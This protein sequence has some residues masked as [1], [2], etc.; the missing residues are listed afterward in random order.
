M[1]R[2]L[3]I[4]LVLFLIPA[5]LNAQN[6]FIK[7]FPNTCDCGIGIVKILPFN[8][9]YLALHYKWAIDKS[10]NAENGFL[11]FNN[12]NDEYKNFVIK[13]SSDY[14]E[15][16]KDFI[17]VGN[18]IYAI[19]TATLNETDSIYLSIYQFNREFKIIKKIYILEDDPSVIF[20]FGHQLSF[21]DSKLLF[22]YNRV[23]DSKT[24]GKIAQIDTL[25]DI[26]SYKSKSFDSPNTLN[27][28]TKSKSGFLVDFFGT[29]MRLD[30]K[31][32]VIEK[33]ENDVE[34][35]FLKRIPF[36]N[37]YIAFG[38]KHFNFKKNRFEDD[39]AIDFADENFKVSKRVLLGKPYGNDRDTTEIVHFNDISWHNPSQI[40]VT[41]TTLRDES[42]ASL[43]NFLDSWVMVS[44]LDSTL[45][46]K[47]TRYYWGDG[48]HVA[49]GVLATNDGGALVYGVQDT[50]KMGV[51]DNAFIMK[52]NSDGLLPTKEPTPFPDVQVVVGA[53][54]F[55]ETCT[56]A[57][58][59]AEELHEAVH[60]EIYN[61]IG[62][63]VKQTTLQ[64]GLNTI[65]FGNLS[66]GIYLYNVLVN[67]QLA[68]SGKLVKVE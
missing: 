51:F 18:S 48:S 40:F 49:Q 17:T 12:Q 1:K 36:K 8:Q 62:Q 11:R 39:I 55:R 27:S 20:L 43:I 19:G 35:S 56:F 34:F 5:C 54:P 37:K 32:N 41:A 46:V 6:T 31:F 21:E 44:Q 9:N 33:K 64:D 22:S 53:N 59:R 30:E 23:K 45:K 24:S 26:G 50:L 15:T 10:E 57:L 58:N 38:Q 2:F 60:L 25:L 29:R 16:F 28:I 4:I 3:P 66:N 13:T 67:K 68:K 65:D 61:N 47:W 52:V 42:S 7:F 63:L 14:N